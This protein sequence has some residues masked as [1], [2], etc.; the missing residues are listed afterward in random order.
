MFTIAVADVVAAWV[1]H[2]GRDADLPFFHI[3]EWI[4]CC[5][6]LRESRRLALAERNDLGLLA[7]AQLEPVDAGR[8]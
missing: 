6:A 2:T 8:A 4:A 7:G 5:C 3:E 1:D